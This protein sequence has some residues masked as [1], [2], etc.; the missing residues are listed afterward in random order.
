M[1]FRSLPQNMY[2]IVFAIGFAL[3]AGPFTANAQTTADQLYL[4]VQRLQAEL[5]ESNQA[6]QIRDQL[7][8]RQL[9]TE[10]G[11]GYSGNIQVLQQIANSFSVHQS[12]TNEMKMV[13]AALTNHLQ[14]LNRSFS[15]DPISAIN[16][17]DVEL[18]EIAPATLETYRQQTLD[19]IQDMDAFHT[20]ELSLYGRHILNKRIGTA[21]LIK[22]LDEA[23]FEL[24]GISDEQKAR[25]EDESDEQYEERLEEL[26]AANQRKLNQD[27]NRLRQ[28]LVL[29]R[30][31]F[32]FVNAEYLNLPFANAERAI[33]KMEEKVIGYL[34]F[35]S[36]NR[37]ALEENLQVRKQVFVKGGVMADPTSRL[38]QAELGRWMDLLASRGQD[39]G[40]QAAVRRR[41]SRPNLKVSVQ[42]SLINR[43]AGQPVSQ[44]D[45]VDQVIVGSRAVGINYT[46]GSVS[47][48]FI[49]SPYSAVVRINLAGMLESSTYTKEGPVTAYTRSTGNFHLNRDIRANI[50]NVTVSEPQAYAKL[51]S[52]FLGTNRIP[53]ITRIASRRFSERQMRAEEVGSELARDQLLDQFTQQT[54]EQLGEGLGQLRE[55]RGRKVELDGILSELRIIVSEVLAQDEDGIAEEPYDLIAP[56]DLP[57]LF[58]SSTNSELNI[59]AT[60]EGENRFAAPVDPPNSFVYADVRVQLHET[61]IS[62]FIAPIVQDR[63]IE[64]WQF[65]NIVSALSRG[66]FTIPEQE[67]PKPFAI[68][69]EDG[70]PIQIEFEGNEL[71][72]TVYGREFRQARNR[73][74]DPIKIHIRFRIMNKDGKLWLV[75]ASNPQVEFTFDPLEGETLSVESIGFRQFLQDNLEA[76]IADDPEANAIELPANLLPLDELETENAELVQQLRQVELVEC[77]FQNGWATLA[78]S[79]TGGYSGVAKNTPGIWFDVPDEVKPK[80]EDQE[81]EEEESSNQDAA[82]SPSLD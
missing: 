76:A 14:E 11:K 54:D 62:N 67:D 73:F 31:E 29:G 40:L 48:D 33:T 27:L 63:L 51:S 79:M 42:E 47:L 24:E 59:G 52:E 19:A 80:S 6:D 74:T 21:S 30:Q 9:E 55:L 34:L 28:R 68:R 20:E 81:G 60:L 25:Q 53:L 8:I 26:Q 16:N 64:S 58:I 75:R 10:S 41:F 70:R 72:V 78:W 15:I 3:L 77:S 57:R 65:P 13:A 17:L 22:A 61:M 37:P 50:G 44:V 46:T 39:D 12:K 5:G 49:D 56:F 45:H 35:Q 38:Y 23:V 2:A 36:R 82:D 32:G 4:A 7:G 1:L 66:E 18:V 71:G 43:V 69:F